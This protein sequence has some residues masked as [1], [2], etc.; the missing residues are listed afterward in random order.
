MLVMMGVTKWLAGWMESRRRFK[1]ERDA[2][3]K[4]ECRGY[5]CLKPYFWPESLDGLNLEQ[6]LYLSHLVII[7]ESGR[8]VTRF[9][10]LKRDSDSIAQSRRAHFTLI[11]GGKE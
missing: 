3:D 8:T 7:D 5:T 1:L 2:I 6:R 10:E 4:M 9:V 11:Q